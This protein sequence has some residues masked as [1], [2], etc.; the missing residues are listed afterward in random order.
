M[1]REV[2]LIHWQL[3]IVKAMLMLGSKARALT[4]RIL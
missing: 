4:M 3:V 2:M 1:P